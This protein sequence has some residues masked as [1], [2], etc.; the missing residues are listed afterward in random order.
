MRRK[1]KQMVE[2]GHTE[3]AE[4]TAIVDALRSHG[5]NQLA[6]RLTHLSAMIA[7]DPDEPGLVIESLRSFAAFFMQEKRLPVPEVGADPQGFLE[8]EW[9]IPARACPL[10][11]P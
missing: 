10:D 2:S 11:I 5:L 9:R 7:D 1:G 4:A 8:A 6:A 3:I